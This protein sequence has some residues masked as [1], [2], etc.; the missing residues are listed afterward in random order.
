[1]DNNRVFRIELSFTKDR[2][3]EGW[4]YLIQYSKD[5]GQNWYPYEYPDHRDHSIEA[6]SKRKATR[7]AKTQLKATQKAEIST[8]TK[9]YIYQ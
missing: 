1:M 9:E 5:L 2:Y 3:R 6:W 7:L 4:T 8:Q